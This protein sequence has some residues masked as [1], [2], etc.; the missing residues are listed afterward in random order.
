M[1]VTT[2]KRKAELTRLCDLWKE[3]RDPSRVISSFLTPRE[4]KYTHIALQPLGMDLFNEDDMTL[5][6]SAWEIVQTRRN[7]FITMEILLVE[8]GLTKEEN[9]GVRLIRGFLQ[10]QH[11]HVNHISLSTIPKFQLTSKV[12][13]PKKQISLKKISIR[14]T[15]G[16]VWLNDSWCFLCHF[17]NSNT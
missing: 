9:D 11:A 10:V 7:D 5:Y 13:K 14:S 2:R 1:G 6:P 12:L 16:E 3:M 8:T 4:A 15:V 17:D